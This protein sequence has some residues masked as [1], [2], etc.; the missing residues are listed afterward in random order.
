[1]ISA[2]LPTRAEIALVMFDDEIFHRTNPDGVI[3][4]YKIEGANLAGWHFIGGYVDGLIASLFIVKDDQMHFW[5]LKG[6]RKHA[7]GL[8]AASFSKWPKDVWCEIPA[9]YQSVINFAKNYGFIQTGINRNSF[10]KNGKLYDKIVLRYSWA[11]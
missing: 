6:Y 10:M 5:V 8:L 1:M 7:R 11:I 9:L 3:N 2:D 4:S